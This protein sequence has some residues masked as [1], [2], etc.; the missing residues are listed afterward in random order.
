MTEMTRIPD[1]HDPERAGDPAFTP[2]VPAIQAAAD[3]LREQEIGRA[4]V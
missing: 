4:H 1:F 2:D 3:A